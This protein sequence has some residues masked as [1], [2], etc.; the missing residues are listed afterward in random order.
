MDGLFQ[1]VATK[2][3]RK[4]TNIVFGEFDVSMNKH[5][6]VNFVSYPTFRF[7][8]AGNKKNPVEINNIE[9]EEEVIKQLKSLTKYLNIIYFNALIL[10][11]QYIYLILIIF[12]IK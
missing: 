4:N 6:D 1:K 10:Y 2:I 8:K 11:Y 9:D 12:I 7:Y 3:S 5:K